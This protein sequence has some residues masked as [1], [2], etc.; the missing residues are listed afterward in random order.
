MEFPVRKY[1]LYAVESI[2]VV[3]ILISPFLLII[4]I[5]IFPIFFDPPEEDIPPRLIEEAMAPDGIWKAQV[6]AFVGRSRLSSNV[7]SDVYSVSIV[8]PARTALILGIDTGGHD[9]QNPRI[10][11]TAPNMLQV[12]VPNISFL[13]VPN[14]AFGD[15]RIDLRYDPDDPAARAAWRRSLGENPDPDKPD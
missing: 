2:G 9:E 14:L 10:V 13:K 8:D 11:W 5:A 6:K 1:F 12:T 7:V 3:A 4:F 15:V